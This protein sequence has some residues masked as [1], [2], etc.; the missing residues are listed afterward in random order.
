LIRTLGDNTP[1]IA[2]T[3]W[4]SEFA[5]VVGN[6]EIGEHCS[7][8]PGVTIRGDG[9]GKIVI[10]NY[11][12]VQEGSVVHGGPMIIEDYVT[13][14]HCVV[15]HCDR[16]GESSL[17]GNNS[18]VLS[19]VTLGNQCLIAANSV[20]LSGSNIPDRSFVT[21]VPGAIKREVTPAQVENMMNNA[22]ELV[23]RA[24]QFRA[25]GL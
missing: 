2:D 9:K 25:S 6:V 7:I 13:V 14:G 20:V 22:R 10:G 4:V 5:Y 24:K 21:G 1:Q 3:A 15:V 23:E 17:L 8:W 19:R 12:N 18:T 16:V 11:V